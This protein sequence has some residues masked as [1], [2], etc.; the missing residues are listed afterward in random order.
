ML[1][2][3]AA[4]NTTRFDKSHNFGLS[5]LRKKQSNWSLRSSLSKMN[6]SHT[7]STVSL[8]MTIT[9]DNTG[10][11]IST[12]TT[13]NEAQEEE[14]KK[15]QPTLI[16]PCYDDE[17]HPWTFRFPKSLSNR[18]ILPREEEGKEVLPDY[19]CTVQKNSYLK[20]K[21]EFSAPGIK[22]I[23]RSWKYYYIQIYGT[24]IMAYTQKPGTVKGRASKVEPVW[25]YSMHGS[26][27]T[28]ASD[29]LKERHV[30][31]LK[32]ENGPQYLINTCTEK[33]KK[34]WIATMETSTNISSD[35]DVRSMPQ[36]I[37]ILSRRNRANG[38]RQVHHSNSNTTDSQL[39]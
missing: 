4:T 21:C 23:I 30:V 34:E 29:Y 10:S 1:H 8:P 11:S 17:S 33:N 28:V 5:W 13:T 9:S 3:S 38:S 24:M 32:L 22:S 27:A 2:S 25:T 6:T 39:L 19:E 26:E 31:R 7:M 15:E 20:V 37:T 18:I 12:T 35:L 14:D 16:P 36:F